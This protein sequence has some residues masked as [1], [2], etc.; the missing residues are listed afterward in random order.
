MRQVYLNHLI[1]IFNY[2]HIIFQEYP[3]PTGKA[4]WS[5][6]RGGTG[7]PPDRARENWGRNNECED[8]KPAVVDVVPKR[9]EKSSKS[10][11]LPCPSTIKNPKNDVEAMKMI[12][13]G[14]KLIEL[15]T[16]YI[17]PQLSYDEKNILH[18]LSSS[19]VAKII[20]KRQVS[21][22]PP[23]SESN[24]HHHHSPSRHSHSSSSSSRSRR[25]PF[26]SRSPSP[27]C[28][29]ERFVETLK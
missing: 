23:G 15:G 14:Q 28:K 27:K 20:T 13:I 29:R 2:T 11:T 21:L 1:K 24:G 17:G 22:P 5:V 7:I 19:I 12:E 6:E 26:N 10:G 16:Q 18:T 8:I 3:W 4:P 25:R 9:S